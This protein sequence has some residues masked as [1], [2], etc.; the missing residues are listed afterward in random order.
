MPSTRFLLLCLVLAS[1]GSRVL[2]KVVVGPEKDGGSDKGCVAPL[3]FWKTHRSSWLVSSLVVGSVKYKAKQILEILNE[4]AGE[5]GLTSLAHQLIAAELNVAGGAGMRDVT[6]TYI[7]NA[8]AMIGE[9]KIPPV[10]DDSLSPR[11]VS[12]NAHRLSLYNEGREGP[13]ACDEGKP[14]PIFAFGP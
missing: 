7:L 3:E 4:P 9:K 6:W 2:G 8:H 12:R 13:P 10:G 5:N 1:F 11:D 14:P